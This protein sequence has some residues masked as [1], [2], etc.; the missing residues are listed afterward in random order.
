MSPRPSAGQSARR[1]V[2]THEALSVAPDLLGLPLA[3]PWRRGAAIAVDGICCAVLANAPGVLFG[4][5]SAWVLWRASRPK[6]NSSGYFRRAVRFSMRAGAAMVLFAVA[7]SLRSTAT[8][9]LSRSGEPEVAGASALASGRGVSASG[10]SAMS[11]GVD[12]ARFYR[13]DDEAAVR[14]AAGD[15]LQQFKGAGMSPS[16]ARAGVRDLATSIKGKPWVLTAVD[17]VLAADVKTDAQPA[18][19]ASPADPDSLVLAYAA[20]LNAGD[21]AS[22]QPLRRQLTSL[23]AADTV[24]S[25]TGTIDGLEQEREELRGTV[26]ELREEAE[27][28]PGIMAL[29]RSLTE[30]L[31]LGFGWFALYFTATTALW[32]GRTPGK[33]LFGIR[34]INLTGKPI[35][36]WTSFERFG[37][38]AAGP[39][40]GLLGFLQIFWDDNRQAIHDKIALTAVVRD[41]PSRDERLET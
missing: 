26:A 7:V 10:R 29:L 25:L 16:E 17:E 9:R 19:P 22:R 1:S 40:T 24:T 20:A 23:L 35:G 28:G 32:H 12:V 14:T 8:N 3:S 36:W 18:T 5:A 6:H 27:E 30:D 41:R 38:Y 37:G 11:L 4:M 31:G 2:V 33:R 21:T 39:A 34:V 15:L 13:A